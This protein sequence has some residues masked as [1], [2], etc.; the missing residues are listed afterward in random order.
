MKVL[1][2]VFNRV[3]KV[4]IKVLPKE[5][6]EEENNILLKGIISDKDKESEDE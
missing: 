5:D 2:V 6:N 4:Q 1:E 3:A